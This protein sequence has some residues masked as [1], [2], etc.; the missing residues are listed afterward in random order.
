MPQTKRIAIVEEAVFQPAA[1]AERDLTRV[2]EL[3]QQGIVENVKIQGFQ[4][5]NK[6]R[7][8]LES[9]IDPK[10][11]EGKPCNIDHPHVNNPND[12]SEMRRVVAQS[13]PFI[14]RFGKFD[15]VRLV[16]GDGLYGRLRFNTK[17][18][19]AET[20]CG[21]VESMPE[22]IGMSP[23]QFGDVYDSGHGEVC[24]RVTDVRHIELVADPA[25]SPK[26]LL[27]AAMNGCGDDP[28]L[29][30]D[31]EDLGLDGATG[32][33]DVDEDLD[34]LGDESD[35]ESDES[36]DDAMSDEDAG[37]GG[38]I[39][40]TPEMF[41]SVT[42]IVQAFFDKQIDEAGAMGKIK[43][44]FRTHAAIAESVMPNA[45][46]PK[47]A[48][49]AIKLLARVATRIKS[50]PVKKALE[51]A[52]LEHRQFRKKDRV[53]TKRD[54]AVALMEAAQLPAHV[55]KDPAFIDE[56][57]DC[58]DAKR[59]QSKI[60]FWRK[61]FGTSRSKTPRSAPQTPLTE[62][63]RDEALRSFGADAG[64]AKISAEDRKKKLD[65]FCSR[66]SGVN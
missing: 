42:K 22:M 46:E 53:Q 59:M 16:P 21:W 47:N 36:A 18:P 64:T 45:P 35:L 1:A 2:R 37:S 32:G 7:T 39:D 62:A 52:L 60:E 12:L 9:G 44:I 13:R 40:I 61:L 31:D 30:D 63:E 33:D 29:E 17:H 48:G 5:T 11:Y 43:Q 49:E 50:Q 19:L 51:I 20:F 54:Q 26:G 56:L 57:L 6:K 15:Q 24:E 25:T 23:A 28:L 55:S 65:E 34:G 8:Y 58:R 10:L 14:S 3:L 4:S 66:Y 27:E 38:S 41:A